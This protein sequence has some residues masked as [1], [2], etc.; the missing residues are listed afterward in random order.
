MPKRKPTVLIDTNILISGLVFLKGNEHKILKLAEDKAITLILPEFVL[1]EARMVL[2]HRFPGHEALL[3]AFVSRTEHAILSSEEMAQSLPFAESR[4]RDAKD[5]PVL[6][7]VL[8]A[9]P[10]FA[11]TGDLAL[12]E[13]LKGC[14]EAGRVTIICSSRQFLKRTV[15]M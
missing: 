4:V 2:A 6:A 9:E 10:D 3:N 7:S 11:V 15:K 12:R 8:V 1:D 14:R 5:V 13:D